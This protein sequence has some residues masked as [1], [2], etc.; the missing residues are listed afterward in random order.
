MTKLGVVLAVLGL[1]FYIYHFFATEEVFPPRERFDAFPDRLGDWRCPERHVIPDD[2]L[3]NLGASDY[4]SCVYVRDE[5]V[6]YVD[7]Y[8][9]YHE[10]QVR[11]EGGGGGGRSIHPPEHCLPG[12]GWD[13]IGS[14]FTEVELPGLPGSRSRVKRWVIAK[15]EARQLVYF[16]YQSRGRVTA[17]LFTKIFATFWDRATRGRTDGSLVRFTTPIAKKGEAAADAR[18]LD[19]ASRVVPELGRFVPE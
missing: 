16:W 9:G 11:R 2:V 17:G 13:I 10:S 1:Q 4:L 19:I 18:I 14:S 3:A 8:V 7:V 15:G 5:P 6:G 12:S